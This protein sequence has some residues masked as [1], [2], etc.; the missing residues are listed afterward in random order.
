MVNVINYHLDISLHVFNDM[1]PVTRLKIPR[2]AVI[3]QILVGCHTVIIKVSHDLK[4]KQ[5]II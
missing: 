5:V 1:N 3:F 2:Q 4:A